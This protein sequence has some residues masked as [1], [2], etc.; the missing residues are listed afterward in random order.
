[1]V[2]DM[3]Y[4]HLEIGKFLNLIQHFGDPAII[5]RSLAID[6]FVQ[7]PDVTPLAWFV[8]ALGRFTNFKTIELQFYD[9][10]RS[11]ISHL[12]QHFKTTLKP[13]LGDAGDFGREGKGLEFHPIDHRHQRREQD[14][15]DWADYLDG[16]RLG[17]D[18]E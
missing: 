8:R 18:K 6:F 1:M 3:A 10:L 13:V 2:I 15:D 17:W 7:G 5:R 14:T 9:Y 11:D 16:I 12:R 4:R